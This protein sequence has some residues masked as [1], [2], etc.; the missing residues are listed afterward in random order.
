MQIAALSDLHIG[1]N[2]RSDSFRHREA[3]FLTFLTELEADHDRII[4]LGD[5]FQTEH[6]WL[7]GRSMARRELGRARRRV[8]SLWRRLSTSPYSYIHGNHDTISATALGA[9]EFLH[10]TADDF[11]I[12]FIHGHQFDPLFRHIY[13]LARAS[14]WFSG[15]LR[16]AGLGPAAD[17]LEHHDVTIKHERF[18]GH[19]GPYASA[20]RRLMREHG[21]DVVVMAHTHIGDRLELDEGILANTGTCM[22]DF[23]YVSIDTVAR[24][25]DLRRR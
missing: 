14:T 24:T 4:I 2:S 6:G 7:P 25:V 20:A 22:R 23:V 3:D 13:P 11:A 5:L 8:P 17:W 18:K 15:R 19:A 12:Y 9:P 1:A 10:L 21:V 16:N